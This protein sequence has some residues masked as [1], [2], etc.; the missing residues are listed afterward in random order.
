MTFHHHTKFISCGQCKKP[1]PYLS[2]GYF[3]ADV[4]NNFDYTSSVA[5]LEMLGWLLLWTKHPSQTEKPSWFCPKC[6]L[7]WRGCFDPFSRICGN[8]F[9]T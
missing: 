3:P 5:L 8:E 6:S 1:A 9:E 7:D 2:P 4:R